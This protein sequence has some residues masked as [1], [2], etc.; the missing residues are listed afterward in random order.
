MEG[1]LAQQEDMFG[2]AEWCDERLV[3]PNRRHVREWRDVAA[4]H[5]AK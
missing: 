1:K 2:T 3:E 4:P 5:R